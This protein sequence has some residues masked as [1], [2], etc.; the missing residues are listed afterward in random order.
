M[1]I[2]DLFAPRPTPT[3]L[4]ADTTRAM[5]LDSLH[6]AQVAASDFQHMQWSKLR[7]F[8]DGVHHDHTS[9]AAG[10]SHPQRSR[11]WEMGDR[12]GYR[13]IRLVEMVAETLSVAFHRPATLYLHLGDYVPLTTAHPQ[14][15]RQVAQWE[16]DQEDA[17]LDT[18]LTH[19]DRA[20]GGGMGQQIVSPSWVQSGDTAKIKW[21]AMDPQ[22]VYIH[23]GLED[24]SDISMA[25]A[26][27]LQ[28]RQPVDSI[29]VQGET[30]YST[31]SRRVEQGAT[32]YYHHVHSAS[33]GEYLNPLWEDNTNGYGVLP[34]V[35]WQV[36]RPSSGCIFIPPDEALLQ[37]QLGLN[38]A[39]TDLFFGLRYQAHPQ[40]VLKGNAIDENPVFG[41]GRLLRIEEDA[42]LDTLTPDLNVDEVTRTLE[43]ALRVQAVSRA[44]P[45]DMWNPSAARNLAALQEQRHNLQLR[46]E[47][48]LPYYKRHL[49]KTWDIHR[50]VG[51]Y[52]AE[53]LGTREPYAPELQLG[54]KLAEIPRVHDRWQQAQSIQLELQQGRTSSIEEVMEAEGVTRE[55]AQ[56]LVEQRQDQAPAV[57]GAPA[58]AKPPG[59]E[60]RPPTVERG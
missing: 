27:L 56:Q 18:T 35:L 25:Q 60:P 11:E 53:R 34:V 59:D 22:E 16:I 36:K 12:A 14:Y 9:T 4:W 26:V 23:Q 19:I 8:L 24:P 32:N 1:S 3:P 55:E 30:I 7:A 37:D 47:R 44:M 20:I 51:N 49:R 15:G 17:E 13:Y 6:R 45:P 28:V 46:R 40:H 54:I 10:I 52:W 50:V 33:G 21:L 31:W 2:L 43:W 57:A 29:G 42:D 48:V 58:P 38:V 39:I 5:V 41:P